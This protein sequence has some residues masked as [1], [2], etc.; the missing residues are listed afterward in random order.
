[1]QETRKVQ[2][3][4]H[5]L[6]SH[7]QFVQALKE[8]SDEEVMHQFQV[9]TVEAFDVIIERFSGRLM[10]FLSSF[11][12]DRS[13]CED[14]MQETFVRVY[15]N[16]Y[17]YKPVAKLATWIFTIAGNL[18]RSEYRRNRRWNMLSLTPQS[19]DEDGEYDRQLESV[20][21]LPDTYTDSNFLNTYI[22]D[23]LNSIPLSFREL[24]VLRDVQQL[25]Y[26]EIAQIT[27]LAMGTV[28]SRINRGR[29]KLQNLLKDVYVAENSG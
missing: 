17:S 1:M 20:F 15:R 19:R 14:L 7:K 28:K 21:N 8:M 2:G 10:N 16:R 11:V 27:G 9:G 4:N 29:G 23:A 25:S 24:I 12:K 18:A 5:L 3:E 22:Q 26:D 6:A 13:T